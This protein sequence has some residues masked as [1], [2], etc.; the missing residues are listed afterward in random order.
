MAA[1]RNVQ[2]ASRGDQS[3][4]YLRMAEASRQ[5]LLA[6]DGADDLPDVYDSLGDG[7][8]G[9]HGLGTLGRRFRLAAVHIRSDC[10][11]ICDLDH[12][13]IHLGT[14]E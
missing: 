6:G 10:H 12:D 7:L 14:H 9:V 11:D 4:A 13:Y 8:P 3:S 5:K 2:P 1:V